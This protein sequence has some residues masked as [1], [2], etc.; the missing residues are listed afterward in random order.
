MGSRR[1]L[2][3]INAIMFQAPI[4]ARRL[5]RDVEQPPRRLLEIGCGDGALMLAVAR[6][7]ARHWPGVELTLLDRQDLVPGE[8]RRR[9]TELGWHAETVITDAIE[10]MEDSAPSSFDVITANLF[11]HHFA[12]GELRRL[13]AAAQ[14]LAPV[15]IATEPRRNGVA[16]VASGLLRLIGANEVTLHDAAAS[17]RAGFAD[18]EL[19][20]LWP[21]GEAVIMREGAI[22]PF[23]HV[24]SARPAASGSP[25]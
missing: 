7:M 23:T 4:V 10:W 14:R 11:L 19:S 2:V 3:R 8:R 16:L 21:R 18:N 15:F 20:A 25:R 12:E 9:F 22:G 6:R 5:R 13:L 17:V 24:F 1:D